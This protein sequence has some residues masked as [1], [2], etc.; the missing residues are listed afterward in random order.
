M[1]E[2]KEEIPIEL[3]ESLDNIKSKGY[4]DEYK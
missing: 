4:I 3:I 1:V 2:R